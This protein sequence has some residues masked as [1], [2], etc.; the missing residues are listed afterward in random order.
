[1]LG[2]RITL[3]EWA[4]AQDG[5]VRIVRDGEDCVC[6]SDG[7]TSRWDDYP[8]YC[9]ACDDTGTVPPAEFAQ[10]AP[11]CQVQLL[12]IDPCPTCAGAGYEGNPAGGHLVEYLPCHDCHGK[13]PVDVGRGELV[14]AAEPTD[15]GKW[16]LRVQVVDCGARRKF[17]W[18]RAEARWN[19]WL[20]NHALKHGGKA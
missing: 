3:A 5:T 9:P 11:S 18:W 8:T 16:A 17:R 1:M 4:S 20:A 7:G 15:D 2:A 14:G 19:Q 13:Q 12:L 10:F 6:S